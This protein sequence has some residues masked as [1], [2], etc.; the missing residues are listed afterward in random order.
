MKVSCSVEAQRVSRLVGQV[1]HDDSEVCV[2]VC[3][4]VCV[5]ESVCV[6]ER[7]SQTI[8]SEIQAWIAYHDISLITLYA[9]D[10][11]HN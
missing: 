10:Q 11:Q 4:F 6:R 2:F 8:M 5:R 1:D 9:L 7:Q 3:L